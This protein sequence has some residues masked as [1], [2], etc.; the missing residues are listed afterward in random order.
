MSHDLRSDRREGLERKA[1]LSEFP[2]YRGAEAPP[3]I[4]LAEMQAALA[5]GLDLRRLVIVRPGL[6]DGKQGQKD[7]P[8]RQNAK[9][10]FQRPA[11]IDMLQHMRADDDVP[12]CV[13]LIDAFD[14]QPQIDTLGVQI[15]GAVKA[16]TRLDMPAHIV[17]GREMKKPSPG[18]ENFLV[19]ERQSEQ[20][21]ARQRFA[22]RAY[23]VI[24]ENIG[25]MDLGEEFAAITAHHAFAWFKPIDP[26]RQ[27]DQL[28]RGAQPVPGRRK[29]PF[30]ES[31]NRHS[32]F[33]SG[34]TFGPTKAGSV[35]CC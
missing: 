5:G 25:K 29:P 8:G 24:C 31:F 19:F 30:K 14:I 17:F 12:A 15:S 20:A 23:R 3:V 13:W 2:A 1:G 22:P 6:H 10:L 4:F 21:V 27:C 28:S 16:N 9:K 26:W 34:W 11:M 33:A 18:I 32:G 35:P 7:A